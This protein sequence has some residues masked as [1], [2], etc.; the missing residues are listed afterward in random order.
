MAD[1]KQ[2][3]TRI[4]SNPN[5][6]EEDRLNAT[7]GR[8]TT[9]TGVMGNP[10]LNF[11]PNESFKGTTSTVDMNTI[12]QGNRDAYGLNGIAADKTYDLPVFKK[13]AKGDK[14]PMHNPDGSIKLHN[15]EQINTTF[16]DSG[17]LIKAFNEL[18]DDLLSIQQETK[19]YTLGTTA[20]LAIPFGKANNQSAIDQITATN[21]AKLD[22]AI[23]AQKGYSREQLQAIQD[24]NSRTLT[25]RQDEA[26]RSNPS[27]MQTLM[28]IINPGEITGRDGNSVVG[29][30]Y[31]P[32]PPVPA[33]KNPETKTVPLAT[34]DSLTH[35][36]TTT[37]KQQRT[38]SAGTN[39][40]S[41]WAFTAPSVATTMNSL[42]T[43]ANPAD[44]G[45]G[46]SGIDS[47]L[48][49]TKEYE[50]LRTNAYNGLVGNKTVQDAKNK[51]W[52]QA[53]NGI[54]VFGTT[55]QRQNQA[56]T[57]AQGGM[58]Q[59]A[60]RYYSILVTAFTASLIKANVGVPQ[61]KAFLNSQNGSGQTIVGTNVAAFRNNLARKFAL[62]M[63]CREAQS[64]DE[65][66]IGVVDTIYK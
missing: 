29:R 42:T 63:L 41:A 16:T 5:S 2:I 30:T 35:S 23:K 7:Y 52:Y 38:P 32:A 57:N 33:F 10:D 55:K 45:L 27:A 17:A 62:D 20:S 44:F 15:Y 34:Y 18:Q 65:V 40:V 54:F 11:D 14:I 9:P 53:G 6:T 31:T 21:K 59:E 3:I 8:R 28:G 25:H 50:Q 48:N 1:A 36:Y 64:G 58:S 24:A 39:T 47:V 61:I 49:K 12:M 37:G 46:L 26:G 60:E 51:A 13:D 22:E 43:A 56:T 66:R 4:L 19:P